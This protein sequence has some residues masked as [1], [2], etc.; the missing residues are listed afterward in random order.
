MVSRCSQRSHVSMFPVFV[1]LK[2]QCHEMDIFFS[3]NILISTFCVSAYG[4]QGLSKDF[5]F[6]IKIL[7]FCLL[8]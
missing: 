2:G 1:L 8:L 7:A 6:S 4:F 3:L 5:H